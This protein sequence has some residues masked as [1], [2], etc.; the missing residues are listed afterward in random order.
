MFR[1]FLIITT[2]AVFPWCHL[3]RAAPLPANGVFPNPGFPKYIES[4]WVQ[5]NDSKIEGQVSIF[6]NGQAVA[7]I[8]ADD[9]KLSTQ[10]MNI[11]SYE[12][13]DS[14]TY[15]YIA[16]QMIYPEKTSAT[17]CVTEF[18]NATHRF[19]AV[20][21]SGDEGCPDSPFAATKIDDINGSKQTHSIFLREEGVL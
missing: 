11:T 1:L 2:M 13:L 12:C 8:L 5:I 21:P 6:Y 18:A 10:M 3:I 4:G 7:Q 20:M 17:I 9:G 19:S 15:R 14:N 16:D